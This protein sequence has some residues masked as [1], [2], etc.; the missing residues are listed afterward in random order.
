MNPQ[1]RA[2]VELVFAGAM[3][4][5][6]FCAQKM[7]QEFWS[8]LVS[9]SLRFGFAFLLSL[10]LVLLM[11]SL[12]KIKLID[13]A[14][15]ALVPGLLLGGVLGFQNY[16]LKFTSV[17]NSGFITTLYI[18]FVPIYDALIFK[19]RIPKGHA[20]VVLVALIGAAMM[21]EVHHMKLNLGDLLTLFCALL[22][23][24]QISWISWVAP[25]IRSPFLFNTLQSFWIGLFSTVAALTLETFRFSG[26]PL[27]SWFGAFH[28]VFFSSIVAF[29]IQ[30]RAQRILS[31]STSSIL[32]LLEA[33]FAALF[34]YWVFREAL[35]PWQMMGGCLILAACGWAIL[36]ERQTRSK[37]L[38]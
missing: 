9:L 19:Q 24:L 33:P 7:A 22:A 35:S 6:G 1:K 23:G 31:S 8:P 3:W 18:L 30:I 34:G 20:K 12:R 21:C 28:L 11:P 5:F 25:K 32:F 15:A 37:T 2:V 13:E 16:G 10:P 29:M 36:L 4:G 26:A 17:A 38:A 27:R 14:R